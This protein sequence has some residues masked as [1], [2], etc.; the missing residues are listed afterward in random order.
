[1][2]P[3]PAPVD[4][5]EK[6]ERPPL[7][8]DTIAFTIGLQRQSFSFPREAQF[9][10]DDKEWLRNLSR[11]F[12]KGWKYGP[13]LPPLLSFVTARGELRSEFLFSNISEISFVFPCLHSR[14][15]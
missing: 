13:K 2:I 8:L 10:S 6:A 1:M 3:F 11:E 4:V 14:W 12:E 9:Q 7:R 5:D 15:P